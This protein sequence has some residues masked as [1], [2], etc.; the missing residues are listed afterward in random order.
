MDHLP[1][2]SNPA[3]PPLEIEYIRASD[4]SIPEYDNEGFS[5]FPAR[6]GWSKQQLMDSQL[7][8][9]IASRTVAGFVQQWLF[10]GILSA[11]MGH[12]YP[13]ETL[14]RDFTRVSATSGK[15]LVTTQRLEQYLLQ[16][17]ADL[18]PLELHKTSQAF[19]RLEAM[20]D[21]TQHH[22]A[23]YMCHYEGVRP[24]HP[25][26]RHPEIS[27]SIMAMGVTL[28]RVKLRLW[29]G[30]KLFAWQQ[31]E[32]ILSRMTEAGWCPSDISMLQKLITA[33]GM[34]YVSLLQPR[35]ARHDHVQ[36]G[37]HKDA[38]NVMNITGEAKQQYRTAHADGCG[39][40]CE[41]EHVEE[42][43]LMEILESGSVPLATFETMQDGTCGL[44]VSE[45]RLAEKI[46]FVAISH[47]WAER[48]G[49]ARDNA[50]PRCQ[51]SRIQKL[52]TAA[53]GGR[54]MPFWIDT[55]SVPQS[56]NKEHLQ[57][58]RLKAIRD[59]DQIYRSSFA[60]LVLDAE[61]Q[62]VHSH[63]PFEELLARF[64]CCS[65]LRRLWTLQ[66]A[67]NGQKVLLQLSDTAVDMMTS[68][69]E[70]LQTFAGFFALSQ[71]VLTE[72]VESIWRV[73]L[74]KN[75]GQ[76]P[77]I[78]TVWNACQFRSTSE[79]QDEAFCLAVVLGLETRAILA[80]RTREDSWRA[81]LLEQKV[82]PK[83]LLF[84]SGP[85][86]QMEG[87]RWAPTRFINRPTTK[88]ATLLL[89][90][91]TGEASIL[92]LT[93]SAS[94][95]VL[96]RPKSP[97]RGEHASFWIRDQDTEQWYLVA[98][99]TEASDGQ[100]SW[101]DLRTQMH[102]MA[103]VGLVI[104][105]DFN[106]QIFALGVLVALIDA[107]SGPDRRVLSGRFLTTVNVALESTDRW[108]TLEE[109]RRQEA[110]GEAHAGGS[111]RVVE[112]VPVPVDQRWCVG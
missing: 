91:G 108:P 54:K 75:P 73:V 70:R 31:S 97:L 8:P 38:C 9:A 111:C 56:N 22:V 92:G 19:N 25:M 107:E 26:D 18:T 84:S 33:S 43:R 34:Y 64:A 112:A 32:L 17:K 3:Y 45:V 96:T 51:L 40:D 37:C 105:Q 60:V 93:V 35:M 100:L 102:D 58:W 69:F 4:L 30:S 62:S 42:A 14:V 20:I 11:A 13:M 110:S 101:S 109:W 87:Y 77:R 106:R 6:A 23:R 72:L 103:K 49:N 104:N 16:W 74:V 71:T 1:P 27:L 76:Y 85:R 39:G 15:T 28:T 10:F 7:D 63:A 48:L 95:Y 24:S 55:L 66:E 65:W 53:A 50:M 67:V 86:L 5:D 21:E 82:F 57:P 41:F 99:R 46:P 88:A 90:M 89:S 98:Q 52:V 83:D 79:A 44:I 94:G 68:I 80:A 78:T 59:M 61:L 81:F 2:V 29:P 36:A 47:V 12:R